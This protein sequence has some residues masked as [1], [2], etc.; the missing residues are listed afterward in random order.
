MYVTLRPEDDPAGS[1]H[2]PGSNMNSEYSSTHCAFVGC[3]LL[4]YELMHG[5]GAHYIRRRGVF[6]GRSLIQVQYSPNTSQLDRGFLLLSVVSRTNAQSLTSR[7]FSRSLLMKPSQNYLKNFRPNQSSQLSQN[8]VLTLPSYHKI[9][10]TSSTS[11]LA[12]GLHPAARF[13]SPS[14]STCR[15]FT[16]LP[17]CLYRKD[18]RAP[19]GPFES[20]NFSR[21]SNK[22]TR[23]TP[24]V[25][26]LFLSLQRVDS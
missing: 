14:I 9:Q 23:Y 1:K 26:F 10:L 6:A 22:N 8:S 17:A 12:V 16:V 24:F 21:S 13:P 2:V 19:P 5:R 15:C 18:E 3:L 4:L 25:F 11:A 7:N 20:S